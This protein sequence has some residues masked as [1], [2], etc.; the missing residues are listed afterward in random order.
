[1][2]K[3]KEMAK[4]YYWLKLK[5]NFF[6]QKEVKKL[7]RI[8]GGD[9]YTIIYLKMQLLSIKKDG[10]I[11]FEGTEKDL[12]EQLSYEIDEDGDNIQTTLLF[13]RANNLI[14]E[15]SENNF[16]L[17]KV[18]DCIGKEGAS[19]ERVRRHRE[20]KALLEKEKEEGLLEEPKKEQEPYSNAKRQRM[21]RA[22]KNCEEKQHIPFI[23]DYMNKKRYNGN[24]Y[25]VLQRDKFRCAL[26][27]SI[28]NLCVHHIDGYDESKPE[29]SN[30]NKMITLC[31]HCHSNVH[32]GSKINEDTLNSIDYYTEYSNVTLPGNAEVTYS[33]DPVTK[34]NTEIEKEKEI[35]KEINNNISKDIF[36]NKVVSEW[37]SIGV[38]PI[39][40]IRGTRQ[41]MLNARIKEYSEE[42]VLQAIN[43]IKHSDFLKGQNKNSWVI[44][45]DWFLKP[46][47]FIKVYE[48]N[49]NSKKKT[50]DPFGN[51]EI[52]RKR[53][54]VPI[55][56]TM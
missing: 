17:T 52:K 56:P 8:A 4:K 1:M 24:Y 18:P 7:R 35:E 46:N 9:T 44:T 6:N 3:E 32:A 37:N 13:L 49:Y 30:E 41:K 19:A 42:G 47:N 54:Y 53:N 33:N 48:D 29:N 11:E 50:N 2:E 38:S 22:K 21:F 16:L 40:L 14:E 25:I 36:I 55:D 5:D 15:I 23:E 10:I 12:A 20:R 31:R 34:S 43:N 39:K 27:S 51:E 45:I 28:E 26:C